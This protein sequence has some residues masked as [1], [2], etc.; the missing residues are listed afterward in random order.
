MVDR[1]NISVPCIYLFIISNDSLMKMVYSFAEKS[2]KKPTWHE[3]KHA[4][5][6]NFGGLDKINPVEVFENTLQ[7]DTNAEVSVI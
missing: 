7:A 4:I 6:R 5:L 1:P 2:D 3:L